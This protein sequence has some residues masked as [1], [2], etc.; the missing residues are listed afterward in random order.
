MLH[1]CTG[2]GFANRGRVCPDSPGGRRPVVLPFNMHYPGRVCPDSPGGMRPVVLPF[3]MHYPGRVCPDSCLAAGGRSFCHLI[4]TGTGMPG[5]DMHWGG[6]ARALPQPSIEACCA[7][8]QGTIITRLAW[9]GMPH[10]LSRLRTRLR[11]RLK[12]LQ[13]EACLR[14]YQN[15]LRQIDVLFLFFLEYSFFSLSV[16]LRCYP[17]T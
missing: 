1:T 9:P 15:L 8:V 2:D 5:L 7:P 17:M 14:F 6:C 10:M 13:S 3:N 16:F 12:W 11:L 4:C